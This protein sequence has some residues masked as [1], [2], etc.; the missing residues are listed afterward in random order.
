[1]KGGIKVSES[2]TK[3]K[4]RQMIIAYYKLNLDVFM[5]REL[6]VKLTKWQRFILRHMRLRDGKEPR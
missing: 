3:E 1:M 4:Q 5:E 2:K 6:E